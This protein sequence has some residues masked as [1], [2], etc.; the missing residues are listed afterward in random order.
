M[1][2]LLT[3]A[4]LLFPQQ[5]EI[6]TD[7]LTAQLLTGH[8]A[9]MR[10]DYDTVRHDWLTAVEQDFSSPLVATAL[11]RIAELDDYCAK[12]IDPA[13]LG[14]LLEGAHDGAVARAL[15][16]LLL[17]EVR[18][19][20]FQDVERPL[21]VGDLYTDWCRNF[22]VLGPV[23][24]LGHPVPLIATQGEPELFLGNAL[25]PS[26]GLELTWLPLKREANQFY[27]RPNSRIR[28][29]QGSIFVTTLLEG[30]SGLAT[31]EIEVDESA[32]VWWNHTEV[33]DLVRTGLTDTE[34]LH[35]AVIE[36]RP[37]WNQ[38]T[39]QTA[40]DDNAYLAARLL[41]QQGQIL[42]YREWDEDDR[43]PQ[44]PL[45]AGAPS[46]PMTAPMPKGNDAWSQILAMHMARLR[47]RPDQALAM[48]KP[49]GMD[50]YTEGAW[51]LARHDALSAS[52]H[53]P[54]EIT[55]R[56]LLMVEARLQELDV[57]C[58]PVEL[59]H[60]D[61]LLEEDRRED[62]ATAIA[63][64]SEAY[65]GILEVELA[66]MQVEFAFDPS[67]IL[68]RPRLLAL[69]ENFPEH[70]MAYE[71]LA[72]IAMEAGDRDLEMSFRRQEEA[73]GDGGGSTVIQILSEGT[74]DDR[75]EA[76]AML[77]RIR[78]EEPNGFR[79]REWERRLHR[80]SGNFSAV[81]AS[82]EEDALESP[83]RTGALFA[84]AELEL[85]QGQRQAAKST[86]D[87]ILQRDPG[88]FGARRMLDWLG[89]EEIA[90]RFFR[91]FAPDHEHALVAKLEGDSG[92]VTKMLDSG[93]IYLWPDGSYRYRVH[94][95]DLAQNRRGTEELHEIAANGSTLQ[96][97]VHKTDGTTREPH[98]VED[99]WVM[100]DLN[101]GDRV[102]MLYDRSFQGT[103]GMAPLLDGWMFQ[104]LDLGF[105]VSRFVVFVPEGLPGEF[106]TGNFDG[107]H[108]ILPWEGG[109]VHI[110][111]RENSM[112]LEPEP[113]MPSRYEVLPW[114]D[115]GIDSS[116]D[117]VA[118]TWSNWFQWQSAVPADVEVELR[119]F[120]AGLSLPDEPHARAAAIFQAL[121]EE[122]LA[123]DQ[124]GDV[125]DVWT[126]KRGNP[127]GL[128]YALLRLANVTVLPAVSSDTA[129]SLD[130]NPMRP[131]P[132]QTRFTTPMLLI[133]GGAQAENTWILL[134]QRG[135]PFASLPQDSYG[136]E[137]LV[138]SEGAPE[139]AH[140]PEA[141]EEGNWT[142]ERKVSYVLQADSSAIVD[143][144][145]VMGGVEGSSV[146]EMIR[147]LTPEEREQAMQSV[148]ASVVPGMDIDGADFLGLDEPGNGFHLVFHGRV[149]DFV[150]Q[151]GDMNGARLN[152]PSEDMTSRLGSGDRE[153]DLAMRMRM[154]AYAQ[155]TLDGGG[156]WTIDYGPESAN[157]HA[158]GLDYRF[159]VE[160]NENRVQLT[161]KVKLDGLYLT[162]EAFPDF[163]AQMR[164]MEQQEQRA[165]RLFRVPE[166]VLEAIPEPELTP[167]SGDE[168]ET[169]EEPVQEGT[170]TTIEEPV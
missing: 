6:P 162:A 14:A 143:G 121:E 73:F 131:F 124:G 142:V 61:T 170:D 9:M 108:E 139:L 87:L 27:V 123:F 59:R 95:V 16:D 82:L 3:F 83:G 74:E 58:V 111:T 44:L 72:D 165:A 38:L 167:E 145:F 105:A 20:R 67:G 25:E 100:P 91:E 110:Y 107:T 4:L 33:M 160:K 39:V 109:Q 47:N 97:L 94:E 104:S 136:A 51:L 169:A 99:S 116:L 81:L 77:A 152:L 149:P 106:V 113:S 45:V 151:R 53:L 57:T 166:P 125:S 122:I 80:R 41:T 35:R 29:G 70:P 117:R 31:L 66:A 18:R 68:A 2:S 23:G 133:P 49:V 154:S 144:S 137:V 147:D 159:E 101:P 126:Q 96:A 7:Q 128:M 92:S 76:A 155:I 62:A 24:P 163:L 64:L 5:A 54:F 48:P 21:F 36:V 84:K 140:L 130:P 79:N 52:F 34:R 150:I 156:A 69:T 13:R 10:A 138:L 88:Q 32:R 146:R 75:D 15:Q 78:K 127:T 134:R 86:L 56:R 118:A 129:D 148:I 115:Y 26:N 161:R 65:P 98:L 40:S 157:L 93:M 37:G 114:V 43:L 141:P 42:S 17:R 112:R 168:G 132:T 8:P 22:R 90:D 102:E 19:T 46:V 60:I 12:G 50:A 71:W 1:I 30:P 85:R 103:P 28:D 153:L 158:D 55:R 135:L 11:E 89:E 164:E 119:E 63:A 120:L